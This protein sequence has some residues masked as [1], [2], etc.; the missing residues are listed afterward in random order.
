MLIDLHTHTSFSADASERAELYVL[1][2]I[3]RNI[4]I[5]G[6]SDHFDFSSEGRSFGHYD[7]DE[8]RDTIASLKAKYSD[9][10]EI[11][12]GVELG[13]SVSFGTEI[14]DVISKLEFDYI[15]G[16]VH[17]I[18]GITLS[19]SSCLKKLEGIKVEEIYGA[20]FSALLEMIKNGVK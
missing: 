9:D 4:S 13:Y 20:Y 11:L 15:I 12:F 3:E 14:V 7:Y 19:E 5:I 1:K 10:I 16:S 17:H 2:A 6:F 8:I 18:N